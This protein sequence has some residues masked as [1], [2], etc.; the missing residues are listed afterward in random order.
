M[1]LQFL[2]V[3]SAAVLLPLLTLSSTFSQ[4]VK[5]IPE[6]NQLD[7]LLQGEYRG[8]SNYQMLIGLQVKAEG[9]GQFSGK[10]FEGGL[11]GNGWYGASRMHELSGRRDRGILT[12]R[13]DNWVVAIRYPYATVYHRGG[14]YVAG[15]TKVV[16]TS[17]TFGAKPPPGAIVLFDPERPSLAEL[18]HARLTPD[19]LLDRGAETKRQFRDFRLHVEFRTPL[20]AAARGQQRGNSGIYL[21]RRY[22]I[23]ILDSFGDS[24]VFNGC[25]AVYRTRPPTV[26]MAFPPGVWQTY[27]IDFSAARFDEQGIKITPA[28]VTV[29]HNGV[30][31]HDHFALPNKTGAGRP[32][33]PSPGP[34]LFQ[35]H[36]DQVTFRYAWVLPL[37]QR[38]AITVAT[39]HTTRPVSPAAGCFEPRTAGRAH[40]ATHVD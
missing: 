18:N 13:S 8:P 38:S 23:Q 25:G 3:S 9:G 7:A 10:L 15:L 20:M 4:V 34:I 40:L 24:P 12:M 31:I 6:G 35:D 27:D 36:R 14:S 26:N 28:V 5:P 22:E 21:Q 29:W 16:R 2:R 32:E 19:G 30:L 37:N 17:S 11:P 33:S 1:N 39:D